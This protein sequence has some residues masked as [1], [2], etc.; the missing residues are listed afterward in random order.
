MGVHGSFSFVPRQLIYVVDW[1]THEGSVNM[2][3]DQAL[4]EH[5]S[6]TGEA[7]LRFYGWSQPTLSLGYFQPHQLRNEHLAS[8]NCAWVRR[9]S[10]GGAILHHHELTY[11]VVLP[12]SHGLSRNVP[13]LYSA[14]HG[15]LIETL[16]THGV[17]LN[18]YGDFAKDERAGS[19]PNAAYPL[20]T[21]SLDGSKTA[22]RAVEG[23]AMEPFLCFKR[24]TAEDLVLGEHK[25]VG[26]AQRR[27]SAAT[28]VHGS[29]LLGRSPFAPELAGLRELTGLEISPEKLALSW[30]PRL[31]SALGREEVVA[32]S[33]P[34]S[35]QMA[36][37]AIEQSRFGAVEWNEKR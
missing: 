36:S 1:C 2:A 6:A 21:A 28:L 12:A 33:L 26:S 29:I 11:A 32:K 19:E 24:R 16:S 14:A 8:V 13:Q 18:R 37:V 4:L 10:G 23:A 34:R 30:L 3:L 22:P 17:V 25:L 7:W 31:A 20:K 15:S 5:S 27:G 35:A 9:A